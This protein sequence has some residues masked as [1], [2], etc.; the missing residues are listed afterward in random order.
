MA[1]ISMGRRNTKLEPSWHGKQK[2]NSLARVRPAGT[3]PWL[4]FHRVQPNRWFFRASIVE[5]MHWMVLHRPVEL[6][7]VIG[8]VP[9]DESKVAGIC[10]CYRTRMT[11]PPKLA[12]YLTQLYGPTHQPEL[13]KE[14]EW[15]YVYRTGEKSY[16]TISKFLL[17]ESFAVYAS[18][19][20]ARWPEM[21]EGR[22]LDFVS[23]FWSKTSWNANDT[24]LLEIIMQDGNDRIWES[25]A[26][27]FLKHPD[28]DRAVGFLIKRL[29]EYTED[30]PLNCI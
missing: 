8:Q 25:C 16:G 29:E 27:A 17:D 9:R 5:S 7:R 28:R 10:V 24:E 22:R 20:R 6:A 4:G 12:E 13:V 26:L 3:L 11:L 14:S 18:D 2:L 21:D 19:I 23:N 30:K 1:V 15:S